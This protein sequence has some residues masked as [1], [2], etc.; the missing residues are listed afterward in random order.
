MFKIYISSLIFIIT[1]VVLSCQDDFNNPSDFTFNPPAPQPDF[2]KTKT[3]ADD[4]LA[5]A[6]KKN[7][8][9][10]Y[11]VLIDFSLHSG[12]PRLLLWN[13][14]RDTIEASALVSHGCGTA[15]WGTDETKWQPQ[16]SNVPES[17]CSS[18]GKYLIK[19]RGWSQ[20]GIHV[21]YLLHG[22][23][24][25]NN[26]ALERLIV[27]HSWEAIEDE[28]TYPVGTPE[29]WG[30]PAVSNAFMKKLDQ[31]FQKEKK[32]VLMWIYV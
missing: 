13:Y 12:V 4:L 9:T 29:G 24:A 17:H 20:W 30:C 27:L 21:K 6:K 25:T 31:L 11:A 32:D 16:L 19:E 7:Y 18:E 22:L 8:N 10:K 26:K 28:A 14:Q 1:V 15:T 5:L 2:A 3:K 23:D